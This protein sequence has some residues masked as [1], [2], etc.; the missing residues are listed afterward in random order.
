[1]F[2]L[3]FGAATAGAAAAAGPDQL[4]RIGPY[5]LI[6]ELR[7]GGMGRVFV[8]R[9]IELG[10]IVALKA[11]TVG[12]GARPE[13]ELR[14]LREAQTIARLRHP[15]IVAVHDSGRA[16]GC[17]Y[18]SM[19]YIE[20]GDLA[21][22]LRRDPPGV[23]AGAHLLRKVAA[24]LEVCA[25]AGRA[26]PG[27]EAVQHPAGRGG[28]AAGRLRA[29]GG[30]GRRRRPDPGHQRSRDAPLPRPGGDAGG[31]RRSV[32][33]QRR[34]C[35]WSRALRAS[36]R[37]HSVR[38][39]VAGR[40]ADAGRRF[41]S[42]GPPPAGA[43]GPAGPGNDLPQVPGTG[44]GAALRHRGGPGGGPAAVPGRRAGARPAAQRRLCIPQVRAAAPGFAG[45]GDRGRGR[46]RGG[47]RRQL[48]PGGAGDPG[49]RAG[50]DGG[51][52]EPGGDELPAER[53][54]GPG[55]AG[56]AAEP[57]SAAAHGARP[58][59]REDR[60]PFSATS[61]WSPPRSK[62][63]WRDLCLP[64]RIRHGPAAL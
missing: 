5:E 15:H 12:A 58:G 50:F 14:F 38:R 31:Q 16:D 60:D 39:G 27:P 2:E 20:G 62:A 55:L 36:D 34:L 42:A 47:D 29:R 30:A 3:E 23:A 35:D 11:V 24:A 32:G 9:Q 21:A 10:R 52:F 41:G 33:R 8:A 63:P 25:R 46:A 43:G 44:S 26:A 7:R 4:D 19:D 18:F 57:G 6:E 48:Q 53:P 22:R 56:R 1:M 17:V 51:G 64:G 40:A 61:R 45:G 49:G 59:R 54:A 13:L 37:P 28:A